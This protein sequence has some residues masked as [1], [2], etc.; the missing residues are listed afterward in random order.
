VRALVLGAT[1]FIGGQ[2]A[3]ALLAEGHAVRAARRPASRTIA[4]DG[5]AVEYASVDLDEAG[6]LEKAAAGCE[7][8]FHAAA[9]YPVRPDRER[10]QLD[11]AKA[12]TSAVI[13]AARAAGA[14]RIVYVSSYTTIG[15]GPD[16]SRPADE[17]RAYRE[18][19][20][21]PLYFRMKALM[22]ERFLESGEGRVPAVVVNPTMCVGPGDVKP[23][24]GRLLLLYARARM[25]FAVPGGFDVVDVRS[26]ARA[27]VRAAFDGRPGERYILPGAWTGLPEFARLVARSANVRA[28]YLPLPF[29][30]ARELARIRE[31]AER[32][33][34]QGPSGAYVQALEMPRRSFPVDG[35]KA[36]RE[37]GL[38][39][40]DIGKAVSD[41]LAWFRERGY[42]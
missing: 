2:I 15:P 8:L 28:A 31:T 7:I 34:P 18:S 30:I 1:G 3:R 4:L 36:R 6:S 20:G 38:E 39:P 35:S 16:P 37:L 33:T 12:S 11:R 19:P 40:T 32:L 41:A 42:L 9:P 5:L 24:M 25:P 14:R 21:D 10:E 13:R 27:A 17:S 23:T 29:G 26:A 22:E